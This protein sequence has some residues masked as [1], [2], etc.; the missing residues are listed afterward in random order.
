MIEKNHSE[1]AANVTIPIV[2]MKVTVSF[3]FIIFCEFTVIFYLIS[4]VIWAFFTQ[5]IKHNH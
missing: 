5:A 4:L 1:K 3:G 2:I